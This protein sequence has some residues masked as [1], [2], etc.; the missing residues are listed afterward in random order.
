M[1]AVMRRAEDQQFHQMVVGGG[2]GRLDDVDILTADILVHLHEDLAVLEGFHFGVGEAHVEAV[3]DSL[4]QRPVC[5]ARDEFHLPAL[6]F[7]AAPH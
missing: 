3:C 7:V 4:G 6:P 1:T 2:R 5:V